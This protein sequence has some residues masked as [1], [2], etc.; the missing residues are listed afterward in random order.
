MNR[1]RAGSALERGNESKRDSH[2]G[3]EGAEEGVWVQ[4]RGA[5]QCRYGSTP[6]SSSQAVM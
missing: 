6:W 3:M 5:R 2:S 1:V 4:Q